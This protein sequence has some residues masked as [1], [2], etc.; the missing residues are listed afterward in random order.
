VGSLKTWPVLWEDLETLIL[1]L[2]HGEGRPPFETFTE[3]EVEAIANET[4]VRWTQH[5]RKAGQIEQGFF[6]EAPKELGLIDKRDGEG[7]V[8]P[9]DH[10]EIVMFAK[11]EAARLAGCVAFALNAELGVRFYT[12]QVFNEQGELRDDAAWTTFSASSPPVDDRCGTWPGIA[13]FFR[14]LILEEEDPYR[15][16]RKHLLGGFFGH[17]D[18]F[19]QD[20]CA[21]PELCWVAG[22]RPEW[23]V[24]EPSHTLMLRKQGFMRFIKAMVNSSQYPDFINIVLTR[25]YLG[26]LVEGTPIEING[27]LTWPMTFNTDDT[28]AA[29]VTT[30]LLDVKGWD[31]SA[32]GMFEQA[33]LDDDDPYCTREEVTWPAVQSL[34]RTTLREIN[35]WSE[36]TAEISERYP[37]LHQKMSLMRKVPTEKLGEIL[38]G[39]WRM[40]C[41]PENAQ[42]PFSYGLIIEAFDSDSMSF[43]GRSRASGRYAVEE[44][45]VRRDDALGHVR[46]HYTEVW[47]NGL[48][49]SLTARLKA[50]GKF[51]CE[52]AQGYIQKARKE[53]TMPSGADE[54]LANLSTKK[55]Y[56]GDKDALED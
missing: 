48:R 31:E 16:A 22:S 35:G 55:Y 41:K 42:Q 10:D 6:G 33:L 43:T 46:I 53:D 26:W 37:M 19:T 54:R 39:E 3:E 25:L 36:W 32:T 29:S 47:P 13:N 11:E 27:R 34:F 30:L 44:G 56:L 18:S 51:H 28:V 17:F 7:W 14:E 21:M 15:I 9:A 40:Y 23:A 38:V 2:T 8:L 1:G 20:G 49:D 45:V 52:S 24:I 50:N 5:E 12:S 4:R